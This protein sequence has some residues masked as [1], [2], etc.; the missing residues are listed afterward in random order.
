MNEVRSSKIFDAAEVRTE[1]R[2]Q[3]GL[4]SYSSPRLQS[5]GDIRGVT[6]GS[7][8]KFDDGQGGLQD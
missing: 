1:V 6:M 7:T 2:N 4:L 8:G 3:K 5:L